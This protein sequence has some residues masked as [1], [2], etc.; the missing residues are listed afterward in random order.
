MVG[1]Q[2][3][4]SQL[5]YIL[6]HFETMGGHGRNKMSSIGLW[7]AGLLLMLLLHYA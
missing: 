5:T 2:R 3:M 6:W 1:N 4:V 7:Q